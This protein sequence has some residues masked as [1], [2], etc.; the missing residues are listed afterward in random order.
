MLVVVVATRTIRKNIITTLN[1]SI[2]R[3]DTIT[4]SP[5]GIIITTRSKRQEPITG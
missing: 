1:L 3:T 5:G 4:T 2:I